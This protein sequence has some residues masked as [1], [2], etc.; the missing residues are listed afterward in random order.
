MNAL[1]VWLAEM[2]PLVASIEVAARVKPLRLVAVAAAWKNCSI[3]GW[4]VAHADCTIGGAEARPE[5]ILAAD[6][7]NAALDFLA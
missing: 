6:W 4:S 7:S 3:C 5:V 1:R 2:N